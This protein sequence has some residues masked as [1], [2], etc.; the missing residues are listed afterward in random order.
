MTSLFDNLKLGDITLN[1]RIIMAPLTRM[2]SQ[3]PGDI[4]GVMNAEY[5]A[6][7]A[8]AGLI[9]S[10]A[11]QISQQA[12]G[13]PGTPGIYTPEQIQGWKLVTDAVHQAGG[14]QFLQL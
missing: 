13:Y 11:T 1:N 12:K 14:K 4:P 5:Y 8:T 6:E 3:Q 9:I 2:R 10:E 7:R